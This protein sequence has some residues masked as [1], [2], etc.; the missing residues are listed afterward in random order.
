MTEDNVSAGILK[1]KLCEIFFLSEIRSC[2][3]IYL[4][5]VKHGSADPDPHQNVT[6]PHTAFN[7]VYVA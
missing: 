7:T 4:S 3:R 1:E 5:E 6:D 2:F